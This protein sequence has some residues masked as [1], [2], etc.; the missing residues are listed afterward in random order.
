MSFKTVLLGGA[1]ALLALPAFAADIMVKDAY[2]RSASAVAKTGAAFMIIENTGSEDDQ[3]V[4]ARSDVSVRVELHTHLSDGDGILRMVE[5]KDGF[6]IPAGGSHALERGGDHVMFM[7]LNEAL[8]DGETVAVTL[9]FEN[10]G[11]IEV[12]IPI[13]SKR[14]PDGHGG[15]GHGHAH[16]HGDHKTN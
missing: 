13:D 14:M 2:A 1:V 4:E 9:V 6:T 12:E 10:A 15:H 16:G 8:V 7:G 5:V 3:L 11:E